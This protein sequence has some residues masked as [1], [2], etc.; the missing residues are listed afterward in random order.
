MVHPLARFSATKGSN[1]VELRASAVLRPRDRITQ[2]ESTCDIALHRV[3]GFERELEG[4][5]GGGRLRRRDGG[6]AERSRD[7]VL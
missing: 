1:A 3:Q 7:T 4:L 2:G 6:L 5:C